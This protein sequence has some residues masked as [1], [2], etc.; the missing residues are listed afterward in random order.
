GPRKHKQLVL[1]D[2]AKARIVERI[3]RDYV[4][5]GRS[6]ND[7]ATQLNAEGV[8]SPGGRGKPWRFDTVKVILENPAYA[9]DFASCRYSY[10]KYHTIQHGTVAKSSGRCR[11]PE[12]EWIVRRDHHEAIIDRGTFEKAQAILAKG[13][14]GR[15]R[16]TPETNPYLLSGLLR[17]GRCGSPLWGLNNGQ[18]RYYECSSMKYNGEDACEG[19]TVREDRILH[20]IADHLDREFVSLDGK[21]LSWKA[22]RKELQ[23]S[24]LP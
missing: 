17:C 12:S 4:V 6:M 23:P 3:F 8:P 14:N 1:D 22:D 15:S 18:H 9:G 10:G 2:P 16:Y 13:K 7:I 21:S 20:A 19:T 24:D 11:R 5:S